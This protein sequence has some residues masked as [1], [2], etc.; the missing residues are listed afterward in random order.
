MKNMMSAGNISS[1]G[2]GV[3]KIKTIGPKQEPA[4]YGPWTKSG[5]QPVFTKMFYEGSHAHL[6]TNF[7]WLHS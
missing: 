2:S 1:S 7:L 4:N 3:T 5:P 6:F